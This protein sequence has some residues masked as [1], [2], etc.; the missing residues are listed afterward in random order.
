[1][2]TARKFR[3]PLLIAATLAGLGFA[4]PARAIDIALGS[5]YVA[6]RAG[7][8]IDI[9]GIGAV[10]FRGLPIGPGS[11]DTVIQRSAD[12]TGLVPGGTATVPIRMT[13]LSLESVSP[14]NIGGSFF[15]VFV[16]L[17]P[18]SLPGDIGQKTIHENST[19]TGGTF[20]SFLQVFYRARAVPLGGGSSSDIFSSTTL[21]A[22]GVP[23]S[24]TPPPGAVILTAP[25]CDST[26]TP[27]APAQV[28]ADQAANLHTGLGS[29]EEDFFT[30]VSAQAI[31]EPAILLLLGSGLAGVA[32]AVGRRRRR[33]T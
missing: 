7:A 8:A 6:T 31:P 24:S 27:C 33:P 19:G 20:T 12:T 11:T 32:G 23:W 3:S 13:A 16:T 1:M 5:D 14:V 4:Q 21:G 30:S 25:D 9:P 2:K 28:A 18:S 22:T 15:D 29:S 26:V 17:D 10:A